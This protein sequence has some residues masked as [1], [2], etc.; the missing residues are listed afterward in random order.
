MGLPLSSGDLS[1]RQEGNYGSTTDIISSAEQTLHER[2][3]T[4]DTH[5]DIPLNYMDEVDPGWETEAQVDLPKMVEGGL[6]AAFFIVYTPQA[7]VSV[8][9]YKEAA[10]IAET[11]YR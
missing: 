8:D 5:V 9:G 2:I 3:L 11:R 10:K 6:D 1:I 4:L 7:Q